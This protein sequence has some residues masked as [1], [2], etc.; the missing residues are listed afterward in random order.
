MSPAVRILN[1]S[2]I[3]LNNYSRLFPH[4]GLDVNTSMTHA[5]DV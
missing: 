2:Y 1:S 3:S 4:P 5:S